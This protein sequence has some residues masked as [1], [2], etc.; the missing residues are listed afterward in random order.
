MTPEGIEGEAGLHYSSHNTTRTISDS[1][2]FREHRASTLPTPAEES[3]NIRGTRFNRPPPVKFPSLGLIVKYGA[4]TTVTEA[5]TQNMVY[6]QLKGK[7][8]VP[9]VFGWTEDGGQVFIY[10]SLIGGEPLEQRWG[11]LNDEEREAVCKELNGMVK[12]WRSLELPDQVLYVGGLDNQ[13][14]NDIFLS[15]HRDLAGPFYGADAVQKFQDGCDIEI[16]GKVPV[17]FTHDDLV[18]SNIL[19]SPGT[20]PVVAAIIDW[21]QAGWYPAYWEHCKARRVRPNPEYFGDDLDEEWNTRYL[22]TVLDPVDDE[23][24]YHPWLWF[25]LSK[26]I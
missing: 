8:P 13:P 10:L 7:V 25:V 26:G 22:P 18:P 1:G 17:V 16:D 4:D 2:F 5:E 24:V 3:D 21:G 9:E 6:K 19:L 12:A 20:N 11:A 15:G 14:L 23:T